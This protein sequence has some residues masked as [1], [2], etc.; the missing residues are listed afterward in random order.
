MTIIYFQYVGNYILLDFE[1]SNQKFPT[2]SSFPLDFCSNFYIFLLLSFFFSLK[3]SH[4]FGAL[5]PP[6][7]LAIVTFPSS[8]GSELPRG[9][10]W[11]GIYRGAVE[12]NGGSRSVINGGGCSH[13]KNHFAPPSA[14]KW[15]KLFLVDKFLVASPPPPF[16]YSPAPQVIPLWVEVEIQLYQY[17]GVSD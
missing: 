12:V 9:K 4:F 16:T 7:F 14:W 6:Y 11:G 5:W 13:W 2:L 1:A 8:S 15:Y 3:T 10:C 17:L